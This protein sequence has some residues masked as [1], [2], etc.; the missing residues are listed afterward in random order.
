[1]RI[2]QDQQVQVDSMGTQHYT[3]HLLLL[4]RNY[5]VDFKLR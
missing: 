3:L 1:M 2:A 4:Q 5:L